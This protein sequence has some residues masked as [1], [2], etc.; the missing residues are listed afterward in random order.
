MANSQSEGN[1][2]RGFLNRRDFL[3]ALAVGATG[4]L[5]SAC[6]SQ[7]TTPTATAPPAAATATSAPAPKPTQPPAAAKTTRLHVLRA[8]SFVPA[9]DKWFSEHLAQ[10]WAKPNNID[11]VVEH[12]GMND[13]QA[14][15][16]TALETGV[17]PD[18][19]M[20]WWNWAHLYAQK[21]LDVSDIAEKQGKDG[22]GYYDVM[23]AYSI[24]DGVWRA[25]PLGIQGMAISYRADWLKEVGES[26]FPETWE[27]Y[28][29]VGK[30]M[31]EKKNAPTGQAWGHSLNDPNNTA[32]CLLWSFGASYVAKDGKTVTINSKQTLDCLEFALQWYH[33]SL[34]PEM[35]GWDDSGNNRAYLAEQIW[36]TH[37]A[38]SIY[39]AAKK[40][41]PQVAQLTEH[42]ENPKGP[43]GRFNMGPMM[44]HAIPSYVKDPKPAKEMLAYLC[45]PK[46]FSTFLAAG[47]GWTS[48][49][50]K[51][52]EN[53]P[54]WKKDPKMALFKD[55]SS[56]GWPGYPGAPTAQSSLV[57]SKYIMVDM[58][59]KTFQGTKPQDAIT[60][61]EEELNRIYASA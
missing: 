21:V 41:F 5:I 4:A 31:K 45:D 34:L 32:H 28:N 23:K 30:I 11:L 20:F 52:H 35:L 24:V 51:I 38:C 3:R 59:A 58:F 50:V 33:D 57:M 14:K 61:A 42:A 7:T 55:V 26:K 1:P 40:D 16:A 36:A 39:I 44:S 47:E 18:V 54:I 15:V 49:P 43:A 27:E 19:M 48:P 60:W 2:K 12:V 22:G 6:A 10:Q 56:M 9:E 37:N 25:V 13:L 17:G 53:D 29:R 8:S 46:V